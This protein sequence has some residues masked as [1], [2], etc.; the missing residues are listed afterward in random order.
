MKDSRVTAAAVKLISENGLDADKL[1]VKMPKAFL[2]HIASCIKNWS[3]IAPYLGFEIGDFE[4]VFQSSGSEKSKK[5]FVLE[6]W[7]T[8][9][10]EEATFCQLIE[11]FL[12]A[13]RE[14]LAER[15]CEYY[16]IWNKEKSK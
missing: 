9:L 3:D 5:L 4:E 16:A 10:G 13:E 14:D 11:I 8:K 6:K 2:I 1:S 15:V 12:V 7:S